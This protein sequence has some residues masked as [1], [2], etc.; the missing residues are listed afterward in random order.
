MHVHMICLDSQVLEYRE[1]K[2]RCEYTSG[3]AGDKS[4]VLRDIQ[5]CKSLIELFDARTQLWGT[6]VVDE[7]DAEREMGEAVR[8]SLRMHRY[9]PTSTSRRATHCS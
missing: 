7:E 5:L 1:F 9:R 3:L 6:D 8:P 4:V 2:R